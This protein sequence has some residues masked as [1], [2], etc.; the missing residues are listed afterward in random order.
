MARFSNLYKQ[1]GNNLPVLKIEETQIDRYHTVIHGDG[2]SDNYRV[3]MWDGKPAQIDNLK[4]GDEIT[5]MM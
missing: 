2:E 4:N 5:E 3:H 1:I